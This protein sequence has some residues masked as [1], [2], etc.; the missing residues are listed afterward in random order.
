MPHISSDSLQSGLQL[1]LLA[2]GQNILWVKNAWGLV[3][4]E[5]L[6][7]ILFEVLLGEDSL[8]ILVEVEVSDLEGVGWVTEGVFEKL[9]LL[10][11]QLYLL[12][13]E[14]GSELGGINNS[15]SKWIMILEE[16]A[17][18]NSVSLDVVSN[19]T[20]KLVARF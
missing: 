19:L 2:V 5:R 3:R 11:R 18:S 13:V 6:L 1:I 12:G 14:S 20:H 16:L 10:V 8:D 15:L 4:G 9:E 7:W 17:N